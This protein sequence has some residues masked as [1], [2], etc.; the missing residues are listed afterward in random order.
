M[1]T[2]TVRYTY[3]RRLRRS[4]SPDSDDA[5]QALR[6]VVLNNG[7]VLSVTVADIAD[8]QSLGYLTGIACFR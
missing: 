2:V 7:M 1:I 3:T 6:D 8:S 5:C 4:H